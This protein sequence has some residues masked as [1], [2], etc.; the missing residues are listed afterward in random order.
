ME[1]DG[2]LPPLPLEPPDDLNSEGLNGKAQ[3]PT[4]PLQTSSD[5]EEMDVSSGGDG[6]T[7]TPAG[8]QGLQTKGS[9]TFINNLS[10]EAEPSTLCPRTARHAPPVTKFLPDL[11]LL[12]DIKISVSVVD[13]SRSKDRKVLYTGIGQ[14]G[15]GEGET[16]SEGLNGEFYDTDTEPG[17]VDG[18]SGL[19]VVGV[20]AGRRGEEAEADLEN[21]VEFAVLD[22]LEDFSHDFLDTEDVQQG[23]FR[24][25]V[26]VQQDH[27]DEENLNISYE[28]RNQR[29]PVFASAEPRHHPL[30]DL[31]CTF[32]TKGLSQTVLCWL[33]YFLAQ[34]QQLEDALQ[35]QPST[36]CLTNENVNG[37]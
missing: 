25:E 6:H 3:P 20:S 19:G 21:K 13:T 26:I 33:E 24:S 12:R 18:S 31:L 7:H 14:E 1:M 32:H 16:S 15:G 11:K 2:I 28:V 22:E 4:P 34:F 36:I 8:D 17:A 23:G 9:I 10:D 29:G 35:C 5:A 27:A 37:L 30:T